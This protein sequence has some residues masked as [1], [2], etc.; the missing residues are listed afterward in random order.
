MG[1]LTEEQLEEVWSDRGLEF[2]MKRFHKFLV[3]RGLLAMSVPEYL[4]L[5]HLRNDILSSFF[6]RGV[7]MY[8]DGRAEYGSD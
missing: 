6:V 4:F 3:E 5:D 2:R 1:I 8:K 7:R